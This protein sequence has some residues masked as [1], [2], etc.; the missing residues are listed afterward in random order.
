MLTGIACN[1]ASIMPQHTNA[2]W[3]L[4]SS[5]PVLACQRIHALPEVK[6]VHM[7]RM[8]EAHAFS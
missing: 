5:A 3:K 1:T 4:T 7:H 8:L 6:V 2:N